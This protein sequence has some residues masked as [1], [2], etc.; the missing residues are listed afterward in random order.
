MSQRGRETSVI[1]SIVTS[2]KL[3][4]ACSQSTGARRSLE[5]GSGYDDGVETLGARVNI[6]VLPAYWGSHRARDGATAE[7][8]ASCAVLAA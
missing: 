8:R 4:E 3:D 1:R 5:Q 7:R 6:R 2:A